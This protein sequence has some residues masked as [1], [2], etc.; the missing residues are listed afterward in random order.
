M[1]VG[2]VRSNWVCSFS[3]LFSGGCRATRATVAGSILI[4]GQHW[5]VSMAV[6]D[7]WLF[8]CRHREWLYMHPLLQR[9]PCFTVCCISP[10]K[11]LLV[12]PELGVSI[13]SMNAM[14]LKLCRNFLPCN[15]N[16][17]LA[18][19]PRPLYLNCKP[20]YQKQGF[21][22]SPAHWWY[23]TQPHMLLW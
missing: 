21:H 4:W 10:C 7:Q 23:S 19:L 5:S 6:S 14:L 17:G 12:W 15:L 16:L 1:L 18:A 3:S 13:F 8:H 11:R 22:L 2:C 9:A 20:M